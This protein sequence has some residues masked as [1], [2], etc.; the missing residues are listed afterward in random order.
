M[1]QDIIYMRSFGPQHFN[2]LDRVIFD[3]EQHKIPEQ[4]RCSCFL[5]GATSCTDEDN[6]HYVIT[7]TLGSVFGH[8]GLRETP[9][10]YEGEKKGGMS[11]MITD[12]DTLTCIEGVPWKST[13]EMNKDEVDKI[14]KE[15]NSKDDTGEN[16]PGE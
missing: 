10:K 1:Q 2:V 5:S 14:N 15:K 13:D 7:W 8:A 16:T 9:G 6:V 4:M 11:K 3:I 12:H